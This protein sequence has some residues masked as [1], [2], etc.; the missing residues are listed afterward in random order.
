MN[1]ALILA[2]GAGTRL[3]ADIPKQYIEINRKPVIAY[4]LEVFD[5]CSDIDAVWVAAR[6]EWQDLIRKYAGGKLKGFSLPGENRQLSILNAL[7][8]IMR[9]ASEKDKVIIHDAA[10]PCVSEKQ[11]RSCIE[12]LASH[13]GVVPVLPM[14][15]TVYSGEQGRISG[16]LERNKILAG[17]A[18]EGFVLGRYYEANRQLLP[19]KIMHINGSTEPAVMAGM[20]VVYIEGEEANFKIT[21][22][23]DLKRFCQICEKEQEREF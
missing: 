1:I 8:D 6:R 9:Y 17:Q 15:D 18:P 14:K 20:D 23:E 3:G 2:G 22:S 12:A 7:E 19:Q 16:L 13:E 4:C 21:T 5:K 11:I 10:R